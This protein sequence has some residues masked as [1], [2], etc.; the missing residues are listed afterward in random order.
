MLHKFYIVVD[1]PEHKLGLHQELEA[2]EGHETV[3]E[4]PVDIINPMPHSEYNSVAMLTQDEADALMSDL[5][6][7][8]VHRDPYELGVQKR[9]TGSRS[10]NWNKNTSFDVT[11][12]NCDAAR[13]Q[14]LACTATHRPSHSRA[15]SSRFCLLRPVSA[16]V[17]PG[18]A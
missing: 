14:R 7:K 10:G 17:T 11:D 13:A 2:E 4:R 9:I 15:T 16:S 1:D 5:R 8:D 3:P 12:K 6:I 18:L